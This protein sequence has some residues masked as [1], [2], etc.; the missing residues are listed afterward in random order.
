[1]VWIVVL[2][3]GGTEDK[4]SVQLFVVEDCSRS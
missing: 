4:S 2:Q 1:M 3:G